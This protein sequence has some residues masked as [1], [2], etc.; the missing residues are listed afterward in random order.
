MAFKSTM[1]YEGVL[2]L[3]SI[4]EIL[5]L[6]G[7]KQA[8]RDGD[9]IITWHHDIPVHRAIQ[10]WWEEKGRFN[11]VDALDSKMC[12]IV[13]VRNPQRSETFNGHSFHTVVAIGHKYIHGE[14]KEC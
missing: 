11:L 14:E 4:R 5:E 2:Q 10:G 12:P 3:A 7:L 8:M 6:A 1:D 13:T 9:I